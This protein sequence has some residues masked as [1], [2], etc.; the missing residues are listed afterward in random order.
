MKVERGFIPVDK[1]QRTNVP[2]I[3]AI[4]D[5][6]R[7]PMLAHKASKEAEVRRRG[8]RRAQGGDGRGRHPGGHLHRPGDRDRRP[9]WSTRRPRRGRKVK[10]GKFPF[11]ALGRA[12]ANAETDGFVKV[13]ADAGDGRVLGSPSSGRRPPT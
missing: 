1:Q 8:D 4:G 2:G 3:Y 6:A 13:V 5:V 7:Q 11:A 9:A 10:I 12:I